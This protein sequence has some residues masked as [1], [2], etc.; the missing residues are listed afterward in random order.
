[1]C[2]FSLKLIFG[3]KERLPFISPAGF[4]RNSSHFRH[5]YA[6]QAF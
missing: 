6:G 5:G 4:G 3:L 1:M 2:I